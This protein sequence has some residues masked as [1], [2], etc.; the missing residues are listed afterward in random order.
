MMYFK[1]LLC[2]LLCSAC[3]VSHRVDGYGTTRITV[4]DTTV[5]HHSGAL[6]YP[7]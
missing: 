2:A 5:L 1:F 3:T 4:T 6:S 7:R